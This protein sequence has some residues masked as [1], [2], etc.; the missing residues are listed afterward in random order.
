MSNLTLLGGQNRSTYLKLKQNKESIQLIK[1]IINPYTSI[2]TDVKG[3]ITIWK[4]DKGKA[5]GTC[6]IGKGG[7]LLFVKDFKATKKQLVPNITDRHLK[8]LIHLLEQD[9]DVVKFSVAKFNR[10]CDIKKSVRAS[11]RH[12]KLIDDLLKY[13]IAYTKDGE[14]QITDANEKNY[15][16][17]KDEVIFKP[18]MLLKSISYNLNNNDETTKE[19]DN[20]LDFTI[21]EEEVTTKLTGANLELCEIF[22]SSN[23]GIMYFHEDLLKIK[24]NSR[25]GLGSVSIAFNIYYLQS[26]NSK[27]Q[28]GTKVI[29]NVST[30][31]DWTGIYKGQYYDFF[32]RNKKVGTSYFINKL[33][34]YFKDLEQIGIYAKFINIE[35]NID[36][37]YKKTQVEFDLTDLKN[38][39]K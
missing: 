21:S 3:H 24:Q 32:E 11:R 8:L 9:L 12:Y 18:V 17:H 20:G 39:F 34:T 10:A 15:S 31:L 1:F 25:V 35:S 4:D 36:K 14:K 7:T 2:D 22:N 13:Q 16:Q 6:Y 33:N 27:K 23:R 37:F 19:I 28:K 26:V 38:N 29:Y 5:I 30:I